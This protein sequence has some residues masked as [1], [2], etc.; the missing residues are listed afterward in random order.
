MSWQNDKESLQICAKSFDKS[1]KL[2][3]KDNFIS[4]FIA[5]FI[6]I[7]SFKKFKKEK[8]LENFATTLG[9]FIF[10]PKNWT[11]QQAKNALPHEA[12]HVTQFR[13]FGLFIHPLLGLPI[14]FLIYLL[15]PIP[16]FLA[17][18]RFLLELDADII[19]WKFL[20]KNN[21]WAKEDV[22]WS[23]KYRINSLSGADYFWC[24]PKS[25]VEKIYIKQAIKTINN[26]PSQSKLKTQKHI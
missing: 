9:N 4:I 6:F 10:I 18:G 3:S 8:Y 12:R 16:I 13:W 22:L 11:T 20:L 23:A 25:W 21:M 2:I 14:G 7:C 17:F 19:K 26:A 15:F 24:L 5:W 1:I